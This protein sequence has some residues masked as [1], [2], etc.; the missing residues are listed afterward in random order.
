[1]HEANLGNLKSKFG[2]QHQYGLMALDI[3]QS[4]EAAFPGIPRRRCADQPPYG[5]IEQSNQC[6]RW[7]WPPGMSLDAERK[8]LE[9]ESKF[10]Q[11]YQNGLIASSILADGSS[12]RRSVSDVPRK[13]CEHQSP[14][15]PP[16]SSKRGSGKR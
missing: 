6:S 2:Q 4:R 9:S 5:P 10:D 16:E 14:Y 15:G 7:G 11:L 1:M 13:T 3:D 12:G 8:L